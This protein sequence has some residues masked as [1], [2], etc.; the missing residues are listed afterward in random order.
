MSNDRRMWLVGL[1]GAGKSTAGRKL[2]ARVG[3]EFFDSDTV[4]EDRTGMSVEELFAAAGVVAFRDL[5][6]QALVGLSDRSGVI[7]TGGG[8]VLSERNRSVMT[9]T[10]LVVYL[11]GSPEVLARRI[12]RDTGRPF[13][14]DRD[15]VEVFTSMREVRHPLYSG[16][17]DRVVNI[18]QASIGRTVSELEELWNA[19]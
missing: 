11:E 18:D 14:V 6:S 7:A 3:S 9:T 13:L 10:G 4:I 5:E 16:L 2:A 19:M 8:A 12:G 1:M 15:P 17:A